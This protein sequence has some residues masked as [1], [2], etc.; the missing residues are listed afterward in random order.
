MM[1]APR[2]FYIDRGFGV[3]VLEEYRA[4]VERGHKVKVVAYRL[5]ESLEGVDI[6][7]SIGLPWFKNAY[8]KPSYNF[9]ILDILLFFKCV[10]ITFS[11]R[12]NIIHAHIHEGGLIGILVSKIFKI[13]V[14]IDTQDFLVDMIE[15]RKLSLGSAF[16]V[17]LFYALEKFIDH[18]VDALI[19]WYVSRKQKIIKKYGVDCKKVFL[20]KEC[21]D[22]NRFNPQVGFQ[23]K[24][25]EELQLPKDKNIVGYLGLLLPTQ[26]ADDLLKIAEKILKQRND[27]HFLIMGFP[28]KKYQDLVVSMGLDS[29]FTFTGGI[30]YSLAHKYLSLCNILISPK[31]TLAEGNGKLLNYLAMGKAIV[32]YDT[33]VNKEII[34]NAGILVEMGNID[35]FVNALNSLLENDYKC[36][37]YEKKAR[38]RSLKEFSSYD[39]ACSIEKVYQTV[40]DAQ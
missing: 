5:G 33:P 10:F 16:I 18:H 40:L 4:L 20:C 31:R 29:Y 39:M 13:P 6:V 27:I 14:I 37:E 35:G 19:S 11:F 22:N 23:K 21:I 28:E 17:R 25:F 34:G 7:R 24:L 15:E 8:S 12:P 30:K 32:V 1:I 38:E 26:G 9:C 2:P 36:L 3:K